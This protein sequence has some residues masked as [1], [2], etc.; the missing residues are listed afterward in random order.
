MDLPLV[1]QVPERHQPDLLLRPVELCNAVI[2]QPG[3]QFLFVPPAPGIVYPAIEFF[4]V[5][6][7][8]LST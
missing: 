2:D 3:K 1:E 6:L 7:S 4:E 5:A 8:S